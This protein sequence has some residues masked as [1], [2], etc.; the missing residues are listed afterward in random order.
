MFKSG[1][2]EKIDKIFISENNAAGS[3]EINCV[4]TYFVA[5]DIN[6]I[7]N[8]GKIN[9]ESDPAVIKLAYAYQN[10]SE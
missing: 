9:F 10:G 6:F 3:I 5:I 1:Q 7:C 4:K 8:I 2:A